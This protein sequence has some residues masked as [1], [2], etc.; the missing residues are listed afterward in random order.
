MYDIGDVVT[1]SATIRDLDGDLADAGTVVCTVALPDGTTTQP[2]VV[3]VGTGTY[4]AQ[5]TCT[6][7]GLHTVRWVA[8]GANA[9]AFTESFTVRSVALATPAR[10]G[11]MLAQ[12]VGD[13]EEVDEGSLNQACVDADQIVLGYLT[14]PGTD[15]LTS[16]ELGVVTVIATRVAARI[17]RNPHNVTVSYDEVP[18]AYSDPR[19]LTPDDR[20]ML[21]HVGFPGFA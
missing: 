17:Y 5:L 18:V 1:L 6:L 7:A 3:H 15:T 11:N 10:V 16:T 19:I 12:A 21:A 2:P 14:L 20:L 4:S 9:G 8:T 13:L